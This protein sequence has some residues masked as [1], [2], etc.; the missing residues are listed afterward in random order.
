MARVL[1]A[2]VAAPED[3]PYASLNSYDLIG[4]GS[5]V[6]YGRVHQRLSSWLDN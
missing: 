1:G 3:V 4:L 2:V 6:Y 5:G